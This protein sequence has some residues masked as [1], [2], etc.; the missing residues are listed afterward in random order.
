M[1]RHLAT[2]RYTPV[3]NSSFGVKVPPMARAAVPALSMSTLS[4]GTDYILCQGSVL[5]KDHTVTEQH[6]V[7]E[8]HP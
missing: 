3:H 7:C 5:E 2:L 4:G 8:L 1:T 6:L